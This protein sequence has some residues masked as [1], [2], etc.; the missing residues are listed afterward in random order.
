MK[1]VTVF[2]GSSLGIDDAYQ[3]DAL[4]L[5]KQLAQQNITLVYGGAKVGIMGAVADAALN[6]GG[7]VIGVI[8]NFLK[9]KEVAH[10]NLTELIVVK[11]M[12]ERKTIMHELC[13]AIIALPGG[14]GTMEELFEVLTWAQLGLHQKPIGLLNTNG[15]YD[16]LIQLITNMVEKGFLKQINQDML[17][18]SNDVNDLL[19]Q[20][21][22]YKAPEV[23]KWITNETI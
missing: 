11:T 9:T 22:N 1:S 23:H 10:D 5:G 7:K 2:C 4:V 21:K 16:A 19:L 15:F 8:P 12:H 13:D 20:M 14:F 18:V 17:L 6:S 3:T